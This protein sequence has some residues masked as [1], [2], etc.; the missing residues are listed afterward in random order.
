MPSPDAIAATV[1]TVLFKTDAPEIVLVRD[2]FESAYLCALVEVESDNYFYLA[3]KISNARLAAFRQGLYDLR[4]L[5]TEPEN[6]PL[7]T[8]RMKPDAPKP[9]LLLEA[10]E[11][12]N[13]DWLP[14]PGF[15]LSD[16]SYVSSEEVVTEAMRQNAAV[17]AYHLDPPESRDGL[18][19]INADRLADWLEKMQVLATKATRLALR[20]LKTSKARLTQFGSAPARLQVYAFSHGSFTVH[21]ASD[22]KADFVGRTAIA[23]GLKKIDELMALTQLP[24][25]EALK[26]LEGNSGHV[27]AAFESVLD[28]VATQESP[29]EYKWAEPAM[30]RAS[31][32]R[33]SPVAA[34]AMVAVLKTTAALKTEPLSFVGYF[35][36]VNTDS[37]PFTWRAIDI[38]GK[39][40]KGYVHEDSPNVLNGITIRDVLH[41]LACDERLE[42]GATGKTRETLYLRSAVKLE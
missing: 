9:T 7:F 35:T 40:R 17:V 1:E 3:V 8:G 36:S 6:L 24:P 30:G 38:D 5:L 15:L 31:G 37:A 20:Q 21:L 42:K 27:L 22:A 2:T 41:T 14:D 39:H 28:L 4:T 33:I 29:L 34:K 19:R 23:A 18:T 12:I 11:S 26:K 13:Q 16:F 25:E 32:Y 10:T